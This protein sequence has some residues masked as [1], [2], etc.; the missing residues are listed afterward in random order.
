[1]PWTALLLTD[2]AKP[3]H[4]FSVEDVSD[5]SRKPLRHRERP[6]TWTLLLTG[7]VAAVASLACEA[8]C[9]DIGCESGVAATL[10]VDS[11][12]WRGGL[13]T[14]AITLDDRHAECSFRLPDDAPTGAAG[15]PN[16]S[17]GTRLELST[18]GDARLRI[19]S[20][21]KQLTLEMARD[22]NNVLVATPELNYEDRYPNGRDC[23]RCRLAVLQLTV[24]D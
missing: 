15:V 3:S 17:D 19:A 14:L 11:G 5:P 16:C 21:P 18:S 1:M 7:V 9:T 4:D 13:Y 24:K 23:E 20:E 22:G 2:R 12:T 8:Y 10:S 6:T